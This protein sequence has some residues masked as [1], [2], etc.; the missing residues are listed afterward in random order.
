MPLAAV[1]DD[2]QLHFIDYPKKGSCGEAM[3]PEKGAF[4]AKQFG[5]AQEGSCESAGYPNKEGTANGTGDKD[6]DKEYDIYSK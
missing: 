2:V 6:S 5:G 1:A 3:V 4:F